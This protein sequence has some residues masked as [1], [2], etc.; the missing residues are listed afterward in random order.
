MRKYGVLLHSLLEETKWCRLTQLP[1]PVMVRLA[2]L[3]VA[4]VP[5][6]CLSY[7]N[8]KALQMTPQVLRSRQ[9]QAPE[10]M[11]NPRK[12]VHIFQHLIPLQSGKLPQV[13]SSLVTGMPPR[14]PTRQ[15]STAYISK[16]PSNIIKASMFDQLM[17]KKLLR[18][19]VN[20]TPPYLFTDRL[21]NRGNV[22]VSGRL[23]L[24]SP[25]GSNHTHP[26]VYVRVKQTLSPANTE[27]RIWRTIN[28]PPND[29]PLDELDSVLLRQLRVPPRSQEGLDSIVLPRKLQQEPPK[30]MIYPFKK[31]LNTSNKESRVPI[32]KSR[33]LHRRSLDENTS[34][35][36]QTQNTV[37]CGEQNPTAA[38]PICNVSQTEPKPSPICNVSKDEPKPTPI[39]NLPKAE[40]TPIPIFRFNNTVKKF[41]NFNNTIYKFN[42]RINNFN[43]FNITINKFN[44][45]INRFN[46]TIYK[47]NNTIYKFNITINRFDNTI[48][49]FNRFNITINKFNNFSNR[50]NRFNA[51]INRFNNTINNFNRFNITINKFNN[52]SKRINNFNRFN[53]TIYKFNITINKFNNT[54][55]NFNRFNITT[56]KFNKFNSRI[57]NF[58]RFNTT[59]YKFNITI[60]RFN[61]TINNFNRFNITTNKFNN[62]NRFNTTIYKFNI[63][64][65]R[66][67]NTI[68][69]FNRFNI[70][71]NNFNSRIN[72][73]N[74]TINRF[75]ITTNKFNN[76]SSRINNFNKFNITI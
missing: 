44:N 59:I 32:L 24:H 5:M 17:H 34:A 42:N 2:V 18:K 51:T 66:F 56:N 28:F 54:I 43:R 46:N 67:N 12:Q 55:N 33:K 40:S 21:P 27:T 8:T 26:M 63:T 49:N 74:I 58:N 72:N 57:N 6:V 53:T 29:V 10:A 22:F 61:N 65:N 75:N 15:P 1:L 64:I 3:I 4:L 73:F 25:L 60:N 45:R 19:S 36:N 41:N 50:I 20:N 35:V 16:H 11:Y 48:N 31:Y 38:P 9:G 62:F 14:T 68:N 13:P 69:N 70:T 7:S 39:C 23:P 47:F 76:F 71:I 30:R 37:T 52:F